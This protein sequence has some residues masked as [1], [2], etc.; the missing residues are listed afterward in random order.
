[1]RPL[2]SVY[3]CSSTDVL[4]DQFLRKHALNLDLPQYFISDVYKAAEVWTPPTLDC[5]PVDGGLSLRRM[6]ARRTLSDVMEALLGAAIATAGV[7]M[8][9]AVGTKL[10]M[11][12]GGK[13]H[14]STRY[15]QAEP[16]S[17]TLAPNLEM[18]EV[19]LDYKF[20]NNRL[21]LEA[22]MHRS[23]PSASLASRSYERLEFLGDAVIE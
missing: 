4:T 1:M 8:G 17:N 9:L 7:E 18:L 2:A 10:Q 12:F 21:L 14:W 15:E 23:C 20:R 5:D 11:C 22:L 13:E 3:L 16:R 19:D 6:V